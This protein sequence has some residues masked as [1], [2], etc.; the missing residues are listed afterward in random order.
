[1][2]TGD[3]LKEKF[4]IQNQQIFMN[5]I[6]ILKYIRYSSYLDI[7]SQVKTV[8][9]TEPN[10]LKTMEFEDSNIETSIAGILNFIGNTACGEF[11]WLAQ[12]NSTN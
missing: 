7:I 12:F 1:M 10:L 11:E 4:H 6:D 2:E 5:T 9:S 8:H 3:E